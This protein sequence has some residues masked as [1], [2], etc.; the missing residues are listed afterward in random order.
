MNTLALIAVISGASLVQLLIQLV[1][2]G[3]IAWLLI[4]F[5]GWVGLPEPFAKVARVVIGLVI[6]VF[7]INLL[8]G[9]GGSAFIVW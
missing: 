5:L 8:L 6:L 4:W 7:L 3:L 1:V 2:V 9:I